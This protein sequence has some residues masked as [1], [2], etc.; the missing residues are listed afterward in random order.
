MPL[1]VKADKKTKISLSSRGMTIVKSN[2]LFTGLK[3]PVLNK[4]LTK[5]SERSYEAGSLIFQDGSSSNQ[6]FM[7]LT[8]RVKIW[9]K[10][11]YGGEIV[12]AILH[13]RD[14]FGELEVIDVLPR[15][16]NAAAIDETTLAVLPRADFDA[17][18]RQ[19][20]QA[21]LNLLHSLSNRLR[22]VDETLIL[23]LERHTDDASRQFDRLHT[24][25]EATKNVNSTIEIDKL[26][27]VILETAR[28]SV[29]ADRGTVY[30]I[31]DL[32]G[33]LWSKV[34]QGADM[35]EI[36]LPIGKGL[37]GS[38]A[39]S[40]EV[41]NLVNAYEDSRFNPEI[42]MKS[43]YHTESML[44]M[45]MKDKDGKIVGV[46]QML[47]KVT[48]TAFTE[49]D[50]EFLDAL[51]V[52]A[53]IAIQNAKMAQELVKSERLS[54]IGQMASA[55]IHD[56]KNPMN[57]IRVY[58]QVIKKKSGNEEAV[59]LADEMIR[60][61]DRLVNMLQEILDFSR[62]VSATKFEKIP[63]GDVMEAILAF[64]EKD[65]VKHKIELV[66]DLRYTGPMVMDPDKMSRVFYNIASNARDAMPNGGKLT[67]RTDLRDS[68]V[69]FEFTDTGTGMPEEVKRR[70]FEPFVTHG[71][72][73]GTGLGMA[74]V[75]KVLDDHKGRIE[76]DSELGKGTTM[77]FIIPVKLRP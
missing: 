47:N 25:I 71:K 4:L 66:R 49:E 34:A 12:L 6:I 64:I 54:S 40:G 7:I 55:I 69:Y 73:H 31:D 13:E 14:F 48:G 8:G 70:I 11:K 37:A 51:S 22:T 32:K 15:S 26:L 2:V 53:S 36:R 72:K 41:V 3:G 27:G 50:V 9:K 68:E 42:D 67:V 76:I 24:L 1:K 46:F 28:K 56:I 20:P 19:H 61:V 60:Q 58:A 62:G 44:T 57:T 30:L 17:L 77:R 59:K 21:T 63:L 33:E 16:A 18:L 23:E 52:G 38:V 10:T 75:K 29:N 74:I 5:F 45:P 35:V 43:G 65:L 39:Q